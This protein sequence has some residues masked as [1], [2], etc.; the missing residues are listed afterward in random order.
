MVLPLGGLDSAKP[1]GY[2]MHPSNCSERESCGLLPLGDTVRR[3]GECWAVGFQP[4]LPSETHAGR[5]YTEVMGVERVILVKA[6]E[7]WG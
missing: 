3:L 5:G 6:R 2:A 1:S 7:A 4:V